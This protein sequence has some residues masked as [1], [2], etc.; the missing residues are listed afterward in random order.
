MSEVIIKYKKINP[1][2]LI[3]FG[4]TEGKGEYVY[5]ESLDSLQLTATVTVRDNRIDIRLTDSFGEEYLLHR[6]PSASGKF[7]GQVKCAY[8]DLVCRIGDKCCD[9]DIFKAVQSLELIEYVRNKY[10]H[11]LEHLWEDT[12]DNA[13]WRKGESKR[14]YAALLTVKRS[15]LGLEGEGTQEVINLKAPPERVA[16]LLKLSGILPAYHM[17]KKHWYTVVLDG[18]LSTER[19]SAL[20]DESYASVK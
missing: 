17:N 13:I 19:V 5:T 7:V 11:E 12:P 16:E 8:D 18:T 15:S 14:W 3:A 1:K 20:I 4:F 6:V 2:K 10:S 9:S